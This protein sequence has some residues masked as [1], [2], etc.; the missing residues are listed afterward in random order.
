[1]SCLGDE[2]EALCKQASG[3]VFIAAP[4][5]KSYALERLLS[6]I[7]FGVKTTVIVRFLP[8]DL[9]SGVTDFEIV[10]RLWGRENTEVYMHQAIHAKLYR[11]DGWAMIGSANVTARALG[12]CAAPNIELLI[13][14]PAS[15]EA[16]FA[17]EQLLRATSVRLTSEVAEMILAAMPAIPKTFEETPTDDRIWIPGCPRPE[18]LWMVYSTGDASTLIREAVMASKRDL[19][20]IAPPAGLR[21]DI[22]ESTIR[23]VFLSSPFFL[24]LSPHLA[25][26]GLSDSEGAEWLTRM[27]HEDLQETAQDTWMVVKRWLRTFGP[28]KLL[29]EAETER[30]RLGKLIA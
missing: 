30:T 19:Q 23:A 16:I 14:Q 12:W 17:V 5:I 1:M 18:L 27:F 26:N 11:I 22:F 8:G 15:H 21:K 2:L 28:D 25:G 6:A 9:A 29:I 7:P 13:K 20:T 10:S 3:D 24:A 4:F